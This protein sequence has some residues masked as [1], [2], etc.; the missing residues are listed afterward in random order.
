MACIPLLPRGFLRLPKRLSKT[1]LRVSPQP[2]INFACGVSFF[3]ALVGDCVKQVPEVIASQIAVDEGADKLEIRVTATEALSAE[4]LALVKNRFELTVA[5][6]GKLNV[7]V[8]QVEK[9]YTTVGGKTP[10]VIRL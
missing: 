8:D 6:A 7:S 5:D 1:S 2:L 10:R 4:K 3:G 9:L